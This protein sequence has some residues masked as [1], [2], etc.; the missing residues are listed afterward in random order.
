MPQTNVD[1]AGTVARTVEIIA[2]RLREAHLN[3]VADAHE[4][5]DFEASQ[6]VVIRYE[7]GGENSL[8]RVIP[9]FR[10]AV[11][12]K[13]ADRLRLLELEASFQLEYRFTSQS[14]HDATALQTFADLNGM[15][16]AYPYWRELVQSVVGRAGIGNLTLPVWRAVVKPAGDL[17]KKD[18]TP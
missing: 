6:E 1:L 5:K 11:H 10:F 4:H 18:S 7:Y 9:T 15:F 2:V 13:Q 3:S 14:P 12:S 8:L 16:N 17:P